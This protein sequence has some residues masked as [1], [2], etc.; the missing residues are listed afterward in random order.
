MRVPDI[1]RWWLVVGL[2]SAAEALF[3]H[4]SATSNKA[5]PILAPE[6]NEPPRFCVVVAVPCSR[7]MFVT[8][9]DIFYHKFSARGHDHCGPIAS[10]DTTA[11][12]LFGIPLGIALRRPLEASYDTI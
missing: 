2:T 11:K 8:I 1:G 9:V 5:Y 6:P 10:S 12:W 4:A 7:R 3:S